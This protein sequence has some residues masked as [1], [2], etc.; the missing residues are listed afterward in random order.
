[1]SQTW[2]NEHF[3]RLHLTK[4]IFELAKK[5]ELVCQILILSMKRLWRRGRVRMMILELSRHHRNVEGNSIKIKR[6]YRFLNSNLILLQTQIWDCTAIWQKTLDSLF[7]LR[8]NSAEIRDSSLAR[9]NQLRV[10][11]CLTIY[12]RKKLIFHWM[13]LF[14]NYAL[15]QL[16]ISSE[17]LL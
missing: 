2:R 3:K 4:E 16:K 13:M 17:K 1:M 6:L 7:I 8:K 14:K 9:E 5:E 15:N 12:Q 11:Q 10:K